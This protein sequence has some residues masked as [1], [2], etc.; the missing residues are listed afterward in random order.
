MRFSYLKI[1]S[2]NLANVTLVVLKERKI[3]GAKALRVYVKC[4]LN[5]QFYCTWSYL[6][7]IFSLLMTC[8]LNLSRIGLL[9]PI[10]FDKLK[11]DAIILMAMF[12]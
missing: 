10:L 4:T 9:Q 1:L 6:L 2:V 12:R 11:R 5:G 3:R 8:Q 7:L